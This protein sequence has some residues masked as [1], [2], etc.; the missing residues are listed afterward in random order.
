MNDIDHEIAERPDGDALILR[1]RIRS[2]LAP[3]AIAAMKTQM[4]DVLKRHP[5]LLV[6]LDLS[7]VEGWNSEAFGMLLSVHKRTKARGGEVRVACLGDDLTRTYCLCGLDRVMPLYN[8]V[9]DAMET[10]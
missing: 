6:V 8:T 7:A 10:R 2:L 3:D 1:L 4:A 9:S 5:C